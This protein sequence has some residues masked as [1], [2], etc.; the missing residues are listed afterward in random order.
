[1]IAS[2]PFAPAGALYKN[3][4]AGFRASPLLAQIEV[5]KAL[6]VQLANELHS[7]ME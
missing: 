7:I 5:V 1:M 3:E 6:R 2:S 4:K